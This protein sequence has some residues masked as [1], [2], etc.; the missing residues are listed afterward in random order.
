MD[1]TKALAEKFIP[2]LEHLHY[3]LQEVTARVEGT[4]KRIFEDWVEQK[5]LLVYGTKAPTVLSK[6]LSVEQLIGMLTSITEHIAS[7]QKISKQI[8]EEVNG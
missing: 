5:P 7:C 3:I 1:E 2:V 6:R 4:K 8:E